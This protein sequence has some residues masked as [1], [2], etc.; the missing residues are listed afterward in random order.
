MTFNAYAPGRRLVA[1]VRIED[2]QAE[3][4]LDRLF[5]DPEVAYIHV[6]NTE[7]GCRRPTA[8]RNGGCGLVPMSWMIGAWSRQA[9]APN[10]NLFLFAKV[11]VARASAP[12]T[13]SPRPVR[14]RG[15]AAC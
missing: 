10:D 15:P 2:G 3:S 12:C 14:P 7:A 5:T 8:P 1:Q 9:W 6:R 4:V 13:T 11:A